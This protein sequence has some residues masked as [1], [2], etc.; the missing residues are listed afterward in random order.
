MFPENPNDTI[1]P[2]YALEEHQFPLEVAHFTPILTQLAHQQLIQDGLMNDQAT[3]Y[4]ASLWTIANNAAKKR[5]AAGQ[6]RLAEVRRQ[7]EE[8]KEAAKLEERKKNK[9][10][11]APL[12]CGKVPSDP[13]VIPAVYAIQKMKVG[14]FCELHYFTNKGLNKAKAAVLVT[15]P[16][17][18]IMLLEANRA[19]TWIPAAAVRD[20]KAAAVTKD[21][22]LSWQEFNKATP[23]MI[24]MMRI[25][26][27]PEDHINMH[28]M[29][30]SVLQNHHW[31]HS[32][33]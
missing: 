4:L 27:W 10:K 28:I 17:A 5:W 7:E 3:H 19:H 33:D 6:R 29:F 14:D 23:Q 15:E 8:D 2:D 9:N 12:R 20:P 21:E 1:V 32:P 18:L 22:N 16:E 11:Y 25:Q 13:S 26:D 30:W 31:C 24:S